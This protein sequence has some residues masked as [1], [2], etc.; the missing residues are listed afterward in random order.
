MTFSV[1]DLMCDVLYEA[2]A[3]A[4]AIRLC[5]PSTG[6]PPPPRP[7]PPKR[8]P[9]RPACVPITT[10]TDAAEVFAPAGGELPILAVL[11]EQLHQAL[12]P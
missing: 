7:K 9:P 6:Q 11:R 2:N 3:N 12:H 1:R 8:P 4:R 10:Q 5:E